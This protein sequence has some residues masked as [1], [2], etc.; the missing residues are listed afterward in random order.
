MRTLMFALLLASCA[1]VEAS[2]HAAL[3]AEEMADQLRELQDKVE[4][5][6]N[7]IGM[8]EDIEAIRVLMYS[9]TYYMDRALFDQV[10]DLFSENME[11][12]EAGGRGVY[13]G[14]ARCIELWQKIWGVY[15]GNENKLKFG[16]MVEHM[17]TK[18]VITVSPDR[19]AAKS[20]GH[21]FGIGGVYQMQQYAGGQTG[22]YQMEYVKEDGVWKIKKFYLP[23]TTTG[24]NFTT[25]SD[26]PGY[27]GCQSAEY[28]PDAPTTNYHPFPEVYVVPFH[29]PNPVS[30]KEVPENGY[31]DPTHYWIGNWP[32]QEGQCGH[33]PTMT[34]MTT[35]PTTP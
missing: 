24:Y 1:R 17:V 8:Q 11:S 14:K 31:T 16:Q 35:Q 26:T 19:K 34:T 20:R 25:W 7:Q 28:P 33:E 22:I 21:Y 15:G 30:G 2:E 32:G 4:Q 3:S 6:Q 29:Y 18:L 12:C 23:F 10:F 27:S 5:L 9:Y 13:K